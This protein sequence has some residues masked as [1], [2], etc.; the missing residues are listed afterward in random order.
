MQAGL[1]SPEAARRAGRRTTFRPCRAALV[2][3]LRAYGAEAR[4]FDG[5]YVYPTVNRVDDLRD[6]TGKQESDRGSG[7][8]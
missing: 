7:A 2:P 4:F 8:L 5:T 3:D 1:L 6:V